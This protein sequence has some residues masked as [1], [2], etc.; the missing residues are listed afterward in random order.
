MVFFGPVKSRP[1][2]RKNPIFWSENRMCGTFCITGGATGEVRRGPNLSGFGKLDIG[3]SGIG[4]SIRHAADLPRRKGRIFLLFI[5]RCLAAVTAGPEIS[6]RSCV[7]GSVVYVRSV[8]CAHFVSY[9]FW[10]IL[11]D[12]W[13]ILADLGRFLALILSAGGGQDLQ[14]LDQESVLKS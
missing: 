12:F 2:I 6:G 10:Q 5:E 1:K 11:A 7:E 14:S 9:F 13:Q 4:K 8:V 3:S